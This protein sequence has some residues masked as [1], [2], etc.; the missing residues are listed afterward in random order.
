[1]DEI[2]D[3]S[4]VLRFVLRRR[5]EVVGVVRATHAC[6]DTATMRATPV[7]DDVRAVLGG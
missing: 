5:D 3:R 2:G 4:F 7:P 1:M 6:I